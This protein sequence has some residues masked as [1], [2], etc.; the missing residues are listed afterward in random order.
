MRLTARPQLA[1]STELRL[2]IGVFGE[3]HPPT[4]TFTIGGQAV[5]PIGNA[6]WSP[7]RD[8]QTGATGQA[9]NHQIVVSFPSQGADKPHLVTV[10]VGVQSV[11]R[12][13]FSTPSA[14]PSTMD[15]SF[16]ILLTSCYFQ[17]E[18]SGGLLGNIVSQLPVRPHMTLM[19]GDQVYLDLPLFEDLPDT[20][21]ALSQFLGNK[22]QKNFLSDALGTAGL[23]S[24]LSRA[25]TVCLPDDHEFWN[26]YPFPQ[27]QLPGTWTQERRDLWASVGQAMYED[28]QQ[29]G[30]PGTAPS[31]WRFDVQPLAILMLDTRCSRKRD[32]KA[33]DGLM[34]QDAASAVLQW[35]ADLIA[36]KGTATPLVGI[37]AGGQ[38]L[39]VEKPSDTA[40]Q[41]QDAEYGNYDQ[42]STVVEGALSR[43]ADA[44]V[45]VV[46][47]T[48]DVHWGRI[49]Q[50][51]H[52]PTGRTSLY[53]VICSPSRLIDTPGADQKAILA[54]KIRGIFG[55]RETW[56]RHSDPPD[57]PAR[58]GN[59][60]E[61]TPSKC[62]GHKGD[63]VALVQFSRAGRGAEMRVTYYSVH[64]DAEVKRPVTCG[65]YPL[66]PL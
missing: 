2:W 66:L 39:F 52:I 62:Y 11:Q 57:P 20:D 55:K 25:P 22:Y 33:A 30:A 31:F 50:A 43:L 26:N 7:I 27:A 37:L 38:A 12:T 51:M 15:G 5:A 45:P 4:P 6:A 36:A 35:E 24:A 32:F 29:G 48:G 19:A 3:E 14:V 40:S 21:P 8:K 61:F 34:R 49:A 44:G 17:P 54:N 64:N 41:L 60:H 16:N 63:Q 46:F 56:P 13:V 58:F 18:D 59:L 47:V 53:E 1:P 42:F 9:A 10:T 28:Y 23:E 65:P